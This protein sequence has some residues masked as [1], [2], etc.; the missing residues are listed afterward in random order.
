VAEFGDQA[1]TTYEK[2][3]LGLLAVSAVPIVPAQTIG[4]FYVERG[5]VPGDFNVLLNGLY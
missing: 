2:A 3:S 5:G 4:E 1:V